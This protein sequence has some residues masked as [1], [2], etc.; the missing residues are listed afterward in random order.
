M[1]MQAID[2]QIKPQ[3]SSAI[4]PPTTNF[5]SFPTD[6]NIDATYNRTPSEPKPWF[7]VDKPNLT[8]YN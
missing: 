4:I 6:A 3:R 8:L 5:S 1:M 2:H 7:S